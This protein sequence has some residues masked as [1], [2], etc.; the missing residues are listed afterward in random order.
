MESADALYGVTMHGD[1]ISRVISQ[2]LEQE[3]APASAG[4]PAAES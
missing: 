3:A 4:T 1:G 2:R